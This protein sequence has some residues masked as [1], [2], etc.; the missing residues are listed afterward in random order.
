MTDQ[1]ANIELIYDTSDNNA[2]TDGLAFKLF[3]NSTVVGQAIDEGFI[4]GESRVD[5]GASVED[6]GDEDDNP[7]TDRYQLFEWTPT[8]AAWPGQGS[9]PLTLLSFSVTPSVD[10]SSLELSIVPVSEATGYEL[11]FESLSLRVGAVSLDIDGDGKAA[12][13]TDGLLVIRYLFGFRGDSL[14]SGAVAAGA[15]RTKAEE[16]EPVIEALIP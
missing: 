9:L 5:A 3:Y 2:E 8:R 11:I 12:P 7:A 14:I 10:V 13:L 1:T 4:F 16:I 6:S 15:T